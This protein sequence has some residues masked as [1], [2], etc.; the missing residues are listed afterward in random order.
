MQGSVQDLDDA[1]RYATVNPV[2]HVIQGDESQRKFL[3]NTLSH[4]VESQYGRK[5]RQNPG[6]HS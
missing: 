2:Y 5:Q 1:C 4:D 3:W 6:S